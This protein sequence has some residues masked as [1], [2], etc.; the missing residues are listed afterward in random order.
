MT[1]AALV[2]AALIWGR[3]DGGKRGYRK[4]A[5]WLLE[6]PLPTYSG[7]TEHRME[8]LRGSVRPLKIFGSGAT[9]GNKDYATPVSPWL[10]PHSAIPA[11]TGMWLSARSRHLAHQRHLSATPAVVRRA[12][13][14]SKLR[15]GCAEVANL[16]TREPGPRRSLLRPTLLILTHRTNRERK[17]LSLLQH[18]PGAARHGL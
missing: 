2:D 17:I 10:I 8:T 6:P 12:L 1:R 16:Q 14:A 4:D 11:H 7:A 3:P 15:Q 18:R 9:V 5:W 13:L